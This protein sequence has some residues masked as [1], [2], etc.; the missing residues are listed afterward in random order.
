M[1]HDYPAA[2]SMD[3]TWFAVDEDGEVAF[4]DTWEGGTM[5]EAGGFPLGGN[6]GGGALG[7]EPEELAMALLQ[8]RAE[9]DPKLAALLPASAEALGEAADY[10]F[11]VLLTLLGVHTYVPE[12][13]YG[14]RPYVRLH[15]VA[16][17]LRLD[18]LPVG[19]RERFVDAKLPVRFRSD[20]R[21]AP[22]EHVSIGSWG[23]TWTDLAGVERDIHTNA[24]VKDAEPYEPPEPPEDE[25]LP[26]LYELLGTYAEVL[27]DHDDGEDR[28]LSW[29]EQRNAAE[30][31]RLKA[32]KASASENSATPTEPPADKADPVTKDVEPSGGSGGILAWLKKL[33]GG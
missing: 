8:L 2:H 28:V 18:E 5:P 1:A 16:R 14:A 6:S 25:A 9:T 3:S 15:E 31:A 30:L 13:D 12:E 33:F 20:L 10:E 21:I 19:I 29:I 32:R 27:Q 23:S 17:A 22:G 26:D 24:P 4:F 11:E 7:L